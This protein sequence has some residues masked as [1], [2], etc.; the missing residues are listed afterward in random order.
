MATANKSKVN[1]KQTTPKAK[2]QQE[3]DELKQRLAQIESMLANIQENPIPIEPKTI[4][5]TKGVDIED[6]EIFDAEIRPNKYIKVMSLTNNTLV[7]TTLPRGQ[8]KV[9]RFE[10]FGIIKNIPYSELAEII[11]NNQTFAEKG[12]FYIMDKQVV[13]NHGLVDAYKNILTKDIIDSI[14]EYK[15]SE[16]TDLFKSATK[17]QKDN[18]VSILINKIVNDEDIDLNK[19]DAISRIYGENLIEKA[20]DAK[21]YANKN[22]A[23]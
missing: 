3:N 18:I 13:F 8:G 17:E 23:G 2:L 4:T 20:E 14:L 21:F 10:K 5:E 15:T 6:D 12:L 1:T 7:L 22:K 11:H 16:M 9:Y 19:V